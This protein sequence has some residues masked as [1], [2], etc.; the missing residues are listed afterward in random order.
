MT[1]LV[2]RGMKR[3]RKDIVYVVLVTFIATFFMSAIL[4]TESI[5]ES[6]LLEKNRDSYGDWILVSDSDAFQHPYLSDR[7]NLSICGTLYDEEDQLMGNLLGSVSDELLSFSRISLYEGHFPE[8]P[9]EIAADLRTLQKLGY[10]YDLGQTITIRWNNGL[11]GSELQIQEQTFTLVGTMKPFNQ[12][13]VREGMLNY[14]DLLICDEEMRSLGEVLRTFW[15]YR[16]DPKLPKID[17][18]EFADSF[19]ASLSPTDRPMCVFNSY[20]YSSDLWQKGMTSGIAVGMMIVL[21]VFAVSFVLA[22]YADGRRAAYYRLRS[23]GCPRSRLNFIIAAECGLSTVPPAF[24]GIGLSYLAGF[25][26]CR[27]MASSMQ[28]R[29]FFG[30]DLKVFL[31]QLAAVFGS[32]LFSVLLTLLRT[33][34]RRLAKETKVLSEKDLQK[35]RKALPKLNRPEKELFL[36][37]RILNRKPRLAAALFTVIMT[38]FLMICSTSIVSAVSVFRLTRKETDFIVSIQNPEQIGRPV[39]HMRTDGTI[40]DNDGVQRYYDYFNPYYGPD[41]QDLEYL[42]DLQG[43]SNMEGR[44]R[45]T[46][47][48]VVWEGMDSSPRFQMRGRITDE[49]GTWTEVIDEWSVELN[50]IKDRAFLKEYCK[51]FGASFTEEQLDA[52]FRGEIVLMLGNYASVYKDQFMT[53]SERVVDETLKDGDL[54]TIRNHDGKELGLPVYHI[55]KADINY[56]FLYKVDRAGSGGLM[57]AEAL[58]E[59]LRQ[60]E[61]PVPE[62]RDNEF[63]FYFNT[64]SSYESTDKILA[65]YAADEKKGIRAIRKASAT[66]F[67][68]LCCGRF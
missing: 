28:L 16:L 65:A 26:V 56:K 63:R 10:S 8:K 64:F 20:V 35:L 7:G 58:A 36:R 57:I 14:P 60:M 4:M 55:E 24:L 42:K 59:Q 3:R 30:F 37:Q 5:L 34:D 48:T 44:S 38:A 18:G 54:I 46:A 47:H 12:L 66:E 40:R 33:G 21:A 43:I 6:Y 15:F 11:I 22:S 68:R 51:E 49:T 41:D 29:G 67:R 19:A 45:D 13:W 25:I 50:V 2:F 17:A 31:L 1:E 61:D 27:I 53:A 23:I 52:F 32:I 9:G 39:R 62:I